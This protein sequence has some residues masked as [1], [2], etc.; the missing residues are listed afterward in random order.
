LC[1]AVEGKR[2][3]GGGKGRVRKEDVKG[4]GRNGKR[5]KREHTASCPIINNSSSA[6]RVLRIKHLAHT[7]SIGGSYSWSGHI[8]TFR[9]EAASEG[10][11]R[12]RGGVLKGG[13]KG[14]EE[15]RDRREAMREQPGA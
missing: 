10:K 4:E 11:K 15:R 9:K 2:S 8:R 6:L 1:G 13:R 14:S 12:G 5:E 3:A 7:G